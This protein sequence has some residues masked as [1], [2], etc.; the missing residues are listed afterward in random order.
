MTT[1]NQDLVDEQIYSW[2]EMYKKSALSYLILTALNS[3][4]MWSKEIEQYIATNTKWSISERALYRVLNRMHKQG[5]IEYSSTPAERTG[6]DRKVYTITSEGSA[7]LAAMKSELDY[8]AK[9]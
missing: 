9:V 3:H 6:A 4:Q 8:L 5:S 1:L 2:T 7:L